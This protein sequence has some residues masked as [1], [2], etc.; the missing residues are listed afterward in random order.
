MVEADRQGRLQTML[1]DRELVP[2]PLTL[3]FG[4]AAEKAGIDLRQAVRARQ[5]V[6]LPV[7]DPAERAYGRVDVEMLRAYKVAADLFGEEVALELARVIGS[8][9]NRLAEAEV[10]AFLR[11]VA[12]PMAAHEVSELAIAETAADVAKTMIPQVNRL[13]DPLHRRHLQFAV[14]RFTASAEELASAPTVDLGVGFAD[15]VGF[16]GLTQQL[17]TEELSTAIA[18]F[19]ARSAEIV[20]RAGGRLVK[21]I[22][23][24]VMYVTDSPAALVQATVELL[25]AF[26]GRDGLPPLRAGLGWGP[27]LA[28][29]GDYFGP[30]VNLASRAAKLARSRLALVTPE[31]CAAVPTPPEGYRYGRPRLYRIKGF[32]GFVRL[33]SLR[34]TR[35]VPA[36]LRAVEAVLGGLP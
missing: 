30:V 27:V 12:A 11:N 4:E 22:G 33:R 17:S 31:I 23:D 36:P 35:T 7:V 3:T 21:L 14:R 1:L 32:E 2:G 6:G 20:T 15:L 8:S 16:T 29:D 28:R 5:A 24:E 25:E 26:S 13:I 18:E 10:S 9:L 34:P 19:E